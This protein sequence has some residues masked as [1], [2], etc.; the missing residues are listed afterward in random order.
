[1]TEQVNEQLLSESVLLP[2]ETVSGGGM[3]KTIYGVSTIT[4]IDR[5]DLVDLA[6]GRITVDQLRPRDRETGIVLDLGDGTRHKECQRC[7]IRKM[8]DGSEQVVTAS[9]YKDNFPGVCF[10]CQGTGRDP[11]G[12]RVRNW[13][14]AGY[15]VPRDEVGN[16]YPI[17]P[18]LRQPIKPEQPQR[19]PLP[20]V[21]TIDVLSDMARAETV[22]S[23]TLTVMLRPGQS[24]DITLDL[25]GMTGQ[26][27]LRL[28][29]TETPAPLPVLPEPDP[30]DPAPR[31]DAL[32]AE[33]ETAAPPDVCEF[34]FAEVAEAVD[35][36]HRRLLIQEIELVLSR[37]E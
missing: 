31:L 5:K 6:A 23:S 26:V 15:D 8:P 17:L 14:D 35:D 25:S 2:T 33:L 37:L 20:P 9:G 3:K 32:L 30:D 10:R 36:D 13:R 18:D 34:Y 22:Q 28:V 27:T 4:D 19:R 1:M 24:G 16:P 7:S 21:R 12:Y 11:G 29:T